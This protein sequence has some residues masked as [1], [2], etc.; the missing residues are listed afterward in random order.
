MRTMV[1]ANKEIKPDIEDDKSRFV[2][3]RPVS[4]SG[5]SWIDFQFIKGFYAKNW[6]GVQRFLK[7]SPDCRFVQYF[8]LEDSSESGLFRKFAFLEPT[9][10]SFLGF[11]NEQG[12][13]GT[14]YHDIGGSKAALFADWV[15]A[16]R[17]MH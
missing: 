5:C 7:A 11:A 13:L 15:R 2:W 14:G 10:E 3:K 6:P 16:N 9:L 4:G 1:K 12:R 8:P 17:V